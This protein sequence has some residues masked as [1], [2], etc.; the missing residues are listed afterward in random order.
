MDTMKD[1]E[2][3]ADA[4]KSKLD[5]DPVTGDEVQTIIAGLFKLSPGIAGK[6]KEV[7]K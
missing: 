2:F 7:L 5:V 6:L 4:R 1:P 3:L